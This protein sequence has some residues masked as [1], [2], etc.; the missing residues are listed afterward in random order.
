MTS[1][2]ELIRDWR[3]RYGTT[4][5]DLCDDARVPMGYALR[6]AKGS[7]VPRSIEQRIRD[8]IAQAEVVRRV[9]VRW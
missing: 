5:R 4:L 6:A 7:T 1:L 3:D 8:L 9:P 2:P